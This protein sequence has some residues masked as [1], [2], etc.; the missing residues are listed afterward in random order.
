MEEEMNLTRKS[1]ESKA[2][3]EGVAIETMDNL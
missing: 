3:Q 1:F 2:L